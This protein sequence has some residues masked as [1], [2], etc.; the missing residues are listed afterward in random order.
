[1]RTLGLAGLVLTLALATAAAPAQAA[2][3]K[4]P[5]ARPPADA[6]TDPSLKRDEVIA[7]IGVKPGDKVADIIS[8]KFAR[9][10][11]A[12]VGPAGKL[13]AVEPTEVVKTHPQ[14]M[15]LITAAAE[16]APGRNI[17]VISAPV[18]ALGLPGGLDAVFI[19]QNYHDLHDKF[20]GPADVAAFNRQVF[21]ALKPG[22]VYVVLDHAAAPGS[23]LTATETLH[24]I[25]PATVKAEVAQAGFVFDGESAVLANPADPHD[26][27]VF[28]PSIRGKT[29]Q[30][31]YRF[32]KPG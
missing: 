13:Y 22:G 29:D 31:L 32:R 15:P 11:S 1:M 19:R 18:N 8:G 12:A 28:D 7:F 9:A 2:D 27:R 24:R 20:M 14:V 6:M 30:F 21:A 5:E 10:L 16:A 17:E 26:K 23:G 25:D 3:A 4:P